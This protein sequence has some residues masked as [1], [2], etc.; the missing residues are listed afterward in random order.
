MVGVLIY[1]TIGSGR[2]WYDSTLWSKSLY[3]DGHVTNHGSILLRLLPH[4]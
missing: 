4:E 1:L 3:Q 2:I